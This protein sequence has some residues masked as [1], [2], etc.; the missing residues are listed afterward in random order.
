MSICLLCNQEM[1]EKVSCVSTPVLTNSGVCVPIRNGDERGF[2]SKSANCGDCGAPKGGFHHRGCDLERCPRCSGQLLCCGCDETD[3]R[4]EDLEIHPDEEADYLDYLRN[5]ADRK[6]FDPSGSLVDGQLFGDQGSVDGEGVVEE[7][8]CLDLYLHPDQALDILNSALDLT[9]EPADR[10]R[11]ARMIHGNSEGDVIRVCL[12]REQANEFYPPI[13]Q[14]SAYMQWRAPYDPVQSR[15]VQLAARVGG[16]AALLELDAIPLPEETFDSSRLPDDIIAKLAGALDEI[17]RVSALAWPGLVG[18]E[19]RT[20][21]Y[22]LLREIAL[23]DPG[24]VRKIENPTKLAAAV[25]WLVG[26]ANNVVSGRGP[27]TASALAKMFGLPSSPS[28]LGGRLKRVLVT[29]QWGDPYNDTSL[30]SPRY[31]IGSVREAVVVE[32]MNL[33]S[34]KAEVNVR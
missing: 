25:C 26:R 19:I 22:R 14:T 13:P 30:K 20:A 9:K 1:R 28:D 16:A 11:L 2:R 10:S 18:V 33:R 23:A 17:A 3:L 12:F 6:T 8:R 7:N 31:L 21:C 32:A 34:K 27:L 24:I 4:P 29:Y 5:H 15:L